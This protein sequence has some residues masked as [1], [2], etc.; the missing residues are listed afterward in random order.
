MKSVTEVAQSI[1]GSLKRVV[2]RL[3]GRGTNTHQTQAAGQS[4]TSSS[5]K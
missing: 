4:P 3:T 5:K 2:S 1:T